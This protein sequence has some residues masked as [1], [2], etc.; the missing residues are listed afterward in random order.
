MQHQL[1]TLP[2]PHS[3]MIEM[4]SQVVNI[5]PYVVKLHTNIRSQLIFTATEFLR[6][7]QDTRLKFKSAR[8]YVSEFT[9]N[10]GESF[11]PLCFLEC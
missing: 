2:L 7:T 3:T 5:T 4:F 10:G 1:W 6:E 8:N 9:F 11:L